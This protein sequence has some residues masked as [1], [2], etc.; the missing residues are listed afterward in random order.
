MRIRKAYTLVEIL[1]VMGIVLILSAIVI[2]IINPKAQRDRAKDTAIKK[3]VNDI[4]SAIEI[5]KASTGRYPTNSDVSYL[6]PYVGNAYTVYLTGGLL[7]F[8][9]A[10]ANLDNGTQSRSIFWDSNSSCLQSSLNEASAGKVYWTPS[11]KI[12]I[13]T[14][15]CSTSIDTASSSTTITPPS[16]AAGSAGNPTAPVSN[17]FNQASSNPNALVAY[18]KMDETSGTEM[19]DSSGKNNNGTFENGVTFDLGVNGGAMRLNGTNQYAQ[20]PN[21]LGNPR[22]VTLSAWVN[23]DSVP[24]SNG[25]EVVS[26]G[27]NVAMRVLQTGLHFF[28]HNS[29]KWVFLS[30]SVPEANLAGKGWTNLVFVFDDNNNSQKMYVNGVEITSQSNTESIVY[31]GLGTITSIGDHANPNGTTPPLHYWFDG[32]IDEVKVWNYARSASQ[33]LA[34]YN[35]TKLATLTDPYLYYKFNETSGTSAASTPSGG[36]AT[37]T[38]MTIPS[39]TSGWNTAGRFDGAVA[40]DG[41]NDYVASAAPTQTASFS[42]STWIYVNA[43]TNGAATDGV[44]T[45]FI[46]R[47][48]ATTPLSSLKAVGNRWCWQI[49]YTNNTG[50]GCALGGTIQTGKWVHLALV[51][52]AGTNFTVYTDGVAGTVKT[53]T[54]APALAIPTP[55]LGIH[56]AGAAANAFNGMID[57]FRVFNYALS[58]AQVNADYRK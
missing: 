29:T 52:T 23:V 48:T 8:Y 49:R 10:D 16:V 34:D 28:Y 41:S 3:S 30:S 36:A 26:I 50:L 45:Y 55:K 6:Q 25:S 1:I 15:G 2:T 19:A 32:R 39:A 35:A 54:G 31:S 42:Y 43:Y 9:S 18:Y 24:A 22:S 56:Q 51:R 4:A 21:M 17:E 33:V 14:T 11:T 37:L 44:G 12:Q 58:A 7:G 46:D 47:T 57:D 53:D 20:V 38:N 27:D 13:G 5:F 40:F